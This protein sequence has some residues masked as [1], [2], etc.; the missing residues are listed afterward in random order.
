MLERC[1]LAVEPK[2]IKGFIAVLNKSPFAIVFD[3]SLRFRT[4]QLGI[5]GQVGLKSGGTIRAEIDNQSPQPGTEVI[6]YHRHPDA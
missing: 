3:K 6:V 4:G 2:N 1:T 5:G